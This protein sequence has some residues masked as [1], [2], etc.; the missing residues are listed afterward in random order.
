MPA[1]SDNKLAMLSDEILKYVTGIGSKV[2]MY[3]EEGASEIDAL[4]ANRFIDKKN[5]YQIFLDSTTSPSTVRVYF[6]SKADVLDPKEGQI[7]YESLINFLR[8]RSKTAPFYDIIVRKYGKEIR[9]KDFAR[10]PKIKKREN[11]I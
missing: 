3:N 11:Y 2:T 5:D 4:K 1:Q 10:I 6:G 7:N 8:E 9:E